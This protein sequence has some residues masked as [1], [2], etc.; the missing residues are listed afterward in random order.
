MMK[1]SYIKILLIIT[2]VAV[3]LTVILSCKKIIKK[4]EVVNYF[5]PPAANEF[6]LMKET[7]T[8]SIEETKAHHI[9]KDIKFPV[10]KNI[11]IGEKDFLTKLN[12]IKNNIDLYKDSVIEVE[13]MY[14]PYS[15]WDKT[16]NYPMIYRNG[17]GCCGDDQYGGFYMINIDSYDVHIDDWIEV[18]GKPFVYDHTDSEG[19][20]QKYLFLLV[21]TLEVKKL[22]DRKAEMVNS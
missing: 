4:Q 5:V 2:L 19:E 21:D 22:R 3:L 16:F 18:K 8:E 20:V 6:A 11:V 12:I 9:Y 14:A 17:P 15:S 10:E 7:E 13:G 1:K